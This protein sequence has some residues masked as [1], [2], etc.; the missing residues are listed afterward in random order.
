MKVYDYRI[1]EKLN[2]DTMKPY[3]IV[4]KYNL[5]L[6]EYHLHSNSPIQ[7]LEEAQEAI[8]ILRKYKGPIYH[9]VE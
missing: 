2:L 1:V 5:H 6:N 8:R 7:T 9:Y 4:E 3:F